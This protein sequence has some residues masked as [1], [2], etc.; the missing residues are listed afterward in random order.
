[1]GDFSCDLHIHSTLSPC[2][3][4]EMSPNKIVEKAVEIGL[5]V[6]AITDHNMT[7]NSFYVREAA[8]KYGL[9]VLCGMELQT[10]EEIHLITVFDDFEVALDFQ[11][12]IY[13]LL[14]DVKNDPEYFGDQVIVDTKDEILHS[15]ERLLLNSVE[16]SIEDAVSWVKS[17]GGLAIPAHIDSPTYSIISQ[18]GFVPDNI[19]FDA[20]E[21]RN[22]EKAKDLLPL[23]MLKNIP[24]VSFSDAHYIADVGRRKT[25]LHMEKPDCQEI[26]QALKA[27]GAERHD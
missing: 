15:E 5:H 21:V 6:I 25:Q 14:P 27:L 19:P 12:R 1:M 4:L 11:Q 16:I 9:I 18:L 3:S 17:H 10:R 2:G 22:I 23:I 26:G 8:K 24:F 7:E 20:L 13:R